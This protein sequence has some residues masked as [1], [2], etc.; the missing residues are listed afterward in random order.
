M[1]L[2]VGQRVS[3]AHRGNADRDASEPVLA[4][5][6]EAH[7]VKRVAGVGQNNGWTLRRA[8][9]VNVSTDS[10]RQPAEGTSSENTPSK[11]R[12]LNRA[13][14]RARTRLPSTGAAGPLQ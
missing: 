14:E 11:P 4:Y 6:E 2:G 3:H 13:A 7:C 12:A 8:A 10:R 5:V 1:G 9:P